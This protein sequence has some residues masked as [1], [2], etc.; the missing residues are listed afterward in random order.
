MLQLPDVNRSESRGMEALRGAVNCGIAW[1][2][3][4]LDHLCPTLGYQEP[5]VAPGEVEHLTHVRS[6]EI[7][8]V[9]HIC[10][11]AG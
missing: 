10:K 4:T 6:R 8:A 1:L 11:F 3:P 5:G 9:D 7:H 2:T